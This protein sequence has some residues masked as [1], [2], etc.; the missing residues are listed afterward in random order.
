MQTIHK[1][2]ID[3]TIRHEGLNDMV[4]VMIDFDNKLKFMRNVEYEG[5]K[6]ALTGYSDFSDDKI[7]S[8]S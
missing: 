3:K 6:K 5:I 4:E 8:F 7:I 2:N 1:N